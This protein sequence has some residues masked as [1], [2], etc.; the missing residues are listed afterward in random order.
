VP[1]RWD[2]PLVRLDGFETIRLEGAVSFCPSGWFCF[3][4]DQEARNQIMAL[5]QETLEYPDSEAFSSQ[6]CLHP[7]GT[8]LCESTPTC[9]VERRAFLRTLIAS[10]GGL[11]LAACGGDGGS[12]R[13]AIANTA[14]GADA[15]SSASA[16]QRFVLAPSGFYGINGHQN[17]VSTYVATPIATQISL[18]QDLG[19]TTMRQDVWD[20]DGAK[21]LVAF[22]DECARNGIRMIVAIT[23]SLPPAG[24]DEDLAHHNAWQL[25][26]AVASTLKGRVHVYEC[27][28]EIELAFIVPGTPGDTA[29][30][31]PAAPYFLYRGTLRG[32]IDGV[33][34]A[35]P[36]AAVGVTSGWL[37]YGVLQ[38]L[39][40]GTDPLGGSGG[41][42]AS[43]DITSWHWY[44]DMGDITSASDSKVNVLDELT[45]RFNVPIWITEFGFRPWGESGSQ[46]WNDQA[47]YLVADLARWVQ[48]KSQYNL[49]QCAMVYELFDSGA[50]EDG[51]GLIASDGVTQKP[52]YSAVKNFIAGNSV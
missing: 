34:A 13:N 17:S 36:S 44:S 32:M 45:R 33:R 26:N 52:A 2:V 35:D 11:A 37:H 9:V 24:T 39:S 10:A 5:R 50:H 51:Y 3:D 18:L 29:S 28:N 38:M 21:N 41:P 14:I 20:L 1:L 43:W 25:G 7:C 46:L 12:I 4:V 22:A 31:Y 19:I 15:A 23:P 40:D 8:P 49:L 27:G 47:N 42:T 16:A 30:N 48:L 6:S